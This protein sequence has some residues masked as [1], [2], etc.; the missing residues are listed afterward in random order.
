MK[1]LI[2]ISLCCF[3]LMKQKYGSFFKIHVH[4]LLK[5]FNLRNISVFT[6]FKR[7]I[8]EEKAKKIATPL[9]KK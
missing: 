3:I 6:T 9:C 4:K 7:G 1:L 2:H 8:P 5:C